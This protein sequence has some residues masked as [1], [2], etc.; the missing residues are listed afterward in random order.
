MGHQRWTRRTTLVALGVTLAGGP[1]AAKD[2]DNSVFLVQSFGP[3]DAEVDRGEPID[4]SAT[5]LNTGRP[6]TQTVEYRIEERTVR[7]RELTL[8]RA[9][10]E[11]ITFEGIETAS[12]RPGERTHGVFTED[13]SERVPLFVSGSPLF[14]VTSVQPRLGE[15]RLDEQFSVS[16]TVR[17]SGNGDGQQTVALRVDGERRATETLSL[18]LNES[19]TVTFTVDSP[20]T[21]GEYSYTVRTDDDDT[22]GA[23]SV[24]APPSGDGGGQELLYTLAGGSGVLALYGG[25]RLFTSLREERT[26][27]PADSP[28]PETGSTG[29]GDSTG[30]STIIETAIDENID[31]AETAATTATRHRSRQEHAQALVACYRA[32]TALADATDAAEEYAPDRLSE[33]EQRRAEL[34][35]LVAE[36]ESALEE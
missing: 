22:S 8:D 1:V 23:V 18:D 34:D 32:R 33:I 21:T 10:Q 16:A 17:N 20:D 30:E 31:R 24:T 3:T 35:E 19:A 14:E 15:T 26:A 36:I 6:G 12:L 5:I 4:V 7:S 25:Y 2:S 11:Q 27:P 28:P 9:Q 13:T 29:F